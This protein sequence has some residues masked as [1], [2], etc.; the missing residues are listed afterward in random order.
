MKLPDSARSLT[1]KMFTVV[2]D[3]PALKLGQ[4]TTGTAAETTVGFVVHIF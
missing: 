1:E 3:I 2:F 4:Q